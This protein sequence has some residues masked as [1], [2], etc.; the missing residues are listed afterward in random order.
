MMHIKSATIYPIVL[1]Q[2]VA[3]LQGE[4]QWDKTSRTASK[5]GVFPGPKCRSVFQT[6]WK[7]T[8]TLRPGSGLVNQPTLSATMVA[9][10]PVFS[11]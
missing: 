9:Q 6:I 4:I 2:N 10:L 3:T 5:F 11:V 8:I 1:V 7:K